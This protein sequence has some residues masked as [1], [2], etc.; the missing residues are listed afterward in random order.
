M[1]I[2][3][4]NLTLQLLP[5]LS[6]NNPAHVDEIAAHFNISPKVVP[7]L[8][9]KL[10]WCGVGEGYGEYIDIAIDED[11]YVTLRDAQGLDRP[12]QLSAEE[13]ALIL[14]GL[15]YLKTVPN[16]ISSDDV[17][18]VLGKLTTA[19]P[20]AQHVIDV[21]MSEEERAISEEVQN[22]LDTGLCIDIE[23][24][25]GAASYARRRIEPLQMKVQ[26]DRTFVTAWCHTQQDYRQF[27]IDRI[28]SCAITDQPYDIQERIKMAGHRRREWPTVEFIATREALAEFDLATVEAM[29]LPDGRLRVKAVVASLDWFTNMVVFAGGGIE[30]LQPGEVV[31]SVNTRAQMWAARNGLG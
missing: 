24:L 30:V 14:N 18:E 29:S 11:Q 25:S 22:A 28:T 4:F 16:V 7:T 12:M 2:D 21:I 3:M 26:D 13:T 1:A 15:A 31:D 5:W 17:Q 8:V 23:Y 20:Q 10:S 6:D 27:R 19:L 9:N